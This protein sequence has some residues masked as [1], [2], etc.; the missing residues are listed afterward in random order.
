MP[1]LH[2]KG[3]VAPMT[4][5]RAMLFI[6][7]QNLCYGMRDSEPS[8]N[9]IDIAVFLR[10]LSRDYEWVR[11]YWFGEIDPEGDLEDNQSALELAG[12]ELETPTVRTSNGETL[13]L[14]TSVAIGMELALQAADDTYDV[15][16]LASGDG[17]LVPAVKRV[18]ALGK[19]VHVASFE[20]P[21]SKFIARQA[22]YLTRLD[23]HA[24]KL[25]AE[26]R[27]TAQPV[28]GP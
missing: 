20:K 25:C 9:G 10:V 24:E 21:L 8:S 14:G 6:D 26:N 13:H 1:E 12:F 23:A 18:Q 5:D 22:D 27:R 19:Q 4:G 3:V 2:P 17:N 16:V 11:A 15:A 7:G 28:G